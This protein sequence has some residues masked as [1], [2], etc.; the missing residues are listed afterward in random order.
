MTFAAWL[1]RHERGG[2]ARAMRSEFQYVD[3]PDR[4]SWAL[5]CVVAAIKQRWVPMDT[6]NL[7]ISRWVMLVETLGCFGPLALGWYLLVF[8][9]P[10]IIHYSLADIQRWYLPLP[11]GAFMA[12]MM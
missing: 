12:S 7:R 5:G 9:Q 2:W 1:M 11:G 8:D 3:T 10:G 4:L 6:G